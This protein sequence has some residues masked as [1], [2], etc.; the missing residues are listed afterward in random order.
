MTTLIQLNYSGKNLFYILTICLSLLFCKVTFGQAPNIRTD[1]SFALFTASG[2]FGNNGSTIICGDVGT[3]VGLYTGSQTVIG[4]VHVA[5]SASAKAARD[6][7]AAYIYMTELSCDSIIEAPFGNDLVLLAGK[8]YC[9]TEATALNGNLILDAQ[10]N[11]NGIFIIKINGAL[12]T[13]TNSNV[14]IKNSAS[15]CNVYWQIGGAV[16]LGENS[17]FK[18]TIIADGAINLLDNATLEGRGLTRAGAISLNNNKVVGCDSSGEPLP[19]SLISFKVKPIG[20]TIQI[21]WST[22]TE[23]NNDYFTIQRS[24]DAVSFK[25]LFNIRGAGNSS[26]ILNYMAIDQQPFNGTIFYRLKQT[27][28]DGTNT[29]SDI[30]FV[31]FKKSFPFTIYP[32]PFSTSTTIALGDILQKMNNCKLKI[33]NIFGE[34]KMSAI[35]T[36]RLTTITTYNLS[37]GTYLYEIISNGENIQSGRIISK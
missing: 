29:F 3:H 24:N 13:A 11:S 7:N 31:H 9:I 21:N 2:A 36:E 32:N 18:G 30:I 14:I 34:E 10:G 22:A 15:F 27:D 28:F 1:S 33:Y 19:I 35:L 6:V 16:N 20:T 17:T 25:D 8:V 12:S 23:I 4:N 37:P 26:S 5:D